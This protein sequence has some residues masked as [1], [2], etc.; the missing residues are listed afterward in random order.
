[1]SDARTTTP[2]KTLL[3]RA[4]LGEAVALLPTSFVLGDGAYDSA[5]NAVRPPQ[6]TMYN[7]TVSYPVTVSRDGSTITATV[8]V[9]PGSTPL[10]YSELGIKTADGTLVLHR[11]LAPQVVTSG[12][13]VTFDFKL[14][15]PEVI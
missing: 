3:A 1:M 6:D 7:Q 4:I 2:Y 10:S 5:R 14:L 11:T 12:I 9:Q 15:P 8:T 13:S